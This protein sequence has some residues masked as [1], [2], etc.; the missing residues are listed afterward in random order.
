[1][2]P[3]QRALL[4]A[5]VYIIL[6]GG[7]ILLSDYELLLWL[8]VSDQL[9]TWQTAKGLFYVGATC[10]IFSLW[11]YRHLKRLEAVHL[12][13]DRGRRR[14]ETLVENVPGIVY[15]CKADDSWTMEYMS[16]ETERVTGYRSDQLIGNREKSFADLILPEHRGAV[17]ESVNNAVELGTSFQLTYPIQT[18]DG[19]VRWLWE[20]G[21]AIEQKSEPIL[22]GLILDITERREAEILR[23]QMFQHSNDLLVI[24]SPEG[25]LREV[26]PA[27]ERVLGWN[28]RELA[29]RKWDDLIHPEDLEITRQSTRQLQA[30]Q[31][32]SG[33]ET[34]WRRQD[35]G[36][37]ILS[38]NLIYLARLGVVFGAARDVT[39]QKELENEF[40]HA[41]KM[42]SLGHLAGG[43]AH[44]FK[45]L[46]T[47]IIAHAQLVELDLPDDSDPELSNSLSQ[48]LEAGRKAADL[49]DRLLVFAR[50][51][52][53][54]ASVA[55]NPLIEDLS[56]L[57]T[58]MLGRNIPVEL[59]LCEGS[60][61]VLL[62]ESQL[63]QVLLNL[64][65]NAKEAMPDGGRLAIR[66]RE[67]SVDDTEF[68]SIAPGDY[69]E[70]V[71]EDTGVGIPEEN[72]LRIFEPFFTTR[73]G[74]GG[75][76]LGLS[77]AY[78]IVTGAGGCI[79]VE[80]AVG[81]GT[82]FRILLPRTGE[83]AVETEAAPVGEGTET[84]L[85]VDDDPILR[86]ALTRLLGRWGYTVLAADNAG[87]A[88]QVAVDYEGPIH[89]LLADIVM[90]GLSGVELSRE[91]AKLRPETRV[92]YMSGSPDVVASA[93]A[94]DKRF[95]RKPFQA[96]ELSRRIRDVLDSGPEGAF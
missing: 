15:R 93:L 9:T 90:P 66:S 54:Q 63:E 42:E 80:S 33:L 45:N 13:L 27:L 68:K 14:F 62:D 41:Q 43:L 31:A 1:M 5:F 82:H 40:L 51:K 20:K 37:C 7:W 65:V 25:E 95:I 4:F 91:L 81:K 17:A 58:P 84:V 3:L 57:L 2:T 72:R 76:G 59:D 75:T 29:G 64:C 83:P 77:T 79:S 87:A 55:V 48:I 16:S 19:G 8:G 53:L 44:D 88:L 85:M 21:R 67:V 30:G 26:N 36:Y 28:R 12:E 50:R 78:A 49:A 61:H 73:E 92:L 38:W 69:I 60:S 46:L 11:L 24:A 86:G 34:R 52:P 23:E 74:E 89:L 70:I 39:R 32:V 35:N 96:E 47:I 56:R 94:A 22:E 18:Q 10:L 71:V 6:G